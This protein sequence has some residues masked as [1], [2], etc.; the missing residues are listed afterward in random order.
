M[1]RVRN[2]SSAV[3]WLSAGF[4][5]AVLVLLIVWPLVNGRQALTIRD[6]IDRISRPALQHVQDA[7][8]SFLNEISDLLYWR[9]TREP[10]YL[11]EFVNH[12]QDVE[13]FMQEIES[14][15]PQ[16]GNEVLEADAALERSLAEWRQLVGPTT[17]T[18]ADFAD[19]SVL[20]QNRTVDSIYDGLDNLQRAIENRLEQQRSVILAL[21]ERETT[22]V[23]ALSLL[24]LLASLGIIQIAR[25]LTR[26]LRESELRREE[27]QQATAA[28]DEVLRIVSHDLRNPINVLSMASYQLA[29]PQ[30]KDDARLRLVG[31]IRRSTDR[32]HRLIQTLLDVGIAQ[33]GRS[34]VL[35]TAN[36][37]IAPILQEACSFSEFD[38]ARRSIQIVCKESHPDVTVFADREK[39]LQA[40]TNLIGN[41]VKFTPERGLITV[42]TAQWD[43]E[44]CVS[45]S[46]SGPGIAEED[47]ARI[48]DPY[49]RGAESQGTGLGLSIVQ[50]I[51]EDHGG[52]VWVSSE[53]GHGTTFSFTLPAGGVH[54]GIQR[55]S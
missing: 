49:Y 16:M 44:V 18:R 7:R 34:L 28:R 43:K 20:R 55:A 50:R 27:A 29:D 39:V 26:S 1:E 48:F 52:R 8:R 14:L 42:S 22:V 32:M 31:I 45:V 19:E 33:S 21:E 54:S 6:E 23:V 4:I 25:R 17:P 3:V 2:H 12:R 9:I 51:V 30:V 15:A 13:R 37:Q 10:D 38:A 35:K 5:V 46:D 47:Q 41:A 24:A 40:L 11:Q 53:L 36:H